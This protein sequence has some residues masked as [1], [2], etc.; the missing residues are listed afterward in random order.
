MSWH[1]HV[2]VATVIEDRGR[3]LLV[4]E[5][6]GGRLV[7]NQPAGHLE[8][9]ETLLEAACRETLEETGW[10]AELDGVISVGL[11]TAPANGVTYMRTTFFGRAVHHDP[12]LPLD[13]GIQRAVWLTPAE[14]A[15]TPEKLRSPMVLQ[16]IHQYLA[17]Q[18]FP[19]ALIFP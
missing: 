8:A 1:P 4:E 18:R 2:T 19:L 17:G 6:A 10:T 16:V 12:T 5:E 11:Y 7:Y 3:F 15:A 14:L 9:G 13:T